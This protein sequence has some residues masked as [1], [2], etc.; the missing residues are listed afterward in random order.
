VT[1]FAH[2]KASRTIKK[3]SILANEGIACSKAI[4]QSGRHRYEQPLE[5]NPLPFSS[6]VERRNAAEHADFPARGRIDNKDTV[7]RNELPV[8]AVKQ[9]QKFYF[10]W[11]SIG[12]ILNITCILSA[13]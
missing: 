13:I 5:H 8:P 7:V 3:E 2:L 6:D 9:Q 1:V 12:K 4:D 10:C 11:R